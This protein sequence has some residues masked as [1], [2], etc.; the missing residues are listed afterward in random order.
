[1]KRNAFLRPVL[2]LLTVGFCTP[3]AICGCDLVTEGT[4]DLSRLGTAIIEDGNSLL[5]GDNKPD[6]Q[7]GGTSTVGSGTR[8]YSLKEYPPTPLPYDRRTAT[9][10]R[11]FIVVVNK[12][13]RRDEAEYQRE[14]ARQNQEVTRG[15]RASVSAS[16]SEFPNAADNLEAA[17]TEEC[18]AVGLELVERSRLRSIVDELDLQLS[19]L[20]DRRTACRVGKLVGADSIIIAQI[21][22]Y[23]YDY[24][25]NYR[26][27]PGGGF[28]FR[29]ANSQI[30]LTVSFRAVDVETGRVLFARTLRHSVIGTVI[31]QANLRRIKQRGVDWEDFLQL[32]ARFWQKIP[33]AFLAAF[34]R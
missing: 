30:N 15:A 26:V 21:T 12:A 11:P 2:W 25:A 3:I 31:G 1:M 17:L 8:P 7:S 28:S 18:L 14:L 6:H 34:K 23:S 13:F 32:D 29:S 16:H 22:C 24:G 5:F 19:S 20:V 9:I 27:Y 4:E 33:R 10:K